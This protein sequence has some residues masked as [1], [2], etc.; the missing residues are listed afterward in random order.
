[1]EYYSLLSCIPSD[2]KILIKND[3]AHSSI[4][5]VA[6]GVLT[7]KQLY[8]KLLA[9]ELLPPPTC[10]KRLTLCGIESKDL[11]QVYLL[12]FKVTKDVKL[13][14]FQYKIIHHILPTNS[15]LYKMKKVTSPYCSFCPAD[16][17]TLWHLFVECSQANSFLAAL[18]LCNRSWTS[19]LEAFN[20]HPV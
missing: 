16:S 17:Q 8:D 18:K 20:P 1:M 9:C 4:P 7:C 5:P 3:S 15:L 12:P 13:S 19:C 10:E 11:S 6:T 14:M 2:W